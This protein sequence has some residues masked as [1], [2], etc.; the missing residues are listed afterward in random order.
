MK[1]ILEKLYAQA[2]LSNSEAKSLFLAILSPDTN[3][4]QIASVLTAFRMRQ[5][6]LDEIFGFRE[7]ALENCVKLEF[8]GIDVVDV[9]GT[10][11]D[12]KNTFNIS[13][14]SAIVVAACGLPV[15]KHGGGAVS[16][17]VGSSNLLEALGVKFT[18]DQSSLLKQLEACNLCF[19][20]A[21]IFHPSFKNVANIRKELG[22]K[23]I[24][25]LLGPI[26]NPAQPKYQTLGVYS[27]ELVKFYRF[28]GQKLEKNY[29]V[30]HTLDGCDEISLTSQAIV[31]DKQGEHLFAAGDFGMSNLSYDEIKEGENISSSV[32]IFN[33]VLNNNATEAQINVV[34][35]NSALTLFQVRKAKGEQSVLLDCVA[36]A[37]EA[38]VSGKA[39]RTFSKLLDL[40]K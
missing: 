1:E 20:H 25:N 13:T 39:R 29:S 5:V 19:L 2:P 33:N 4:F 36:E 12:N 23:T 37:K 18:N 24:F 7:A 3:Q 10:G 27:L 6:T 26:L 40:A 34:T 35:A 30:V 38:I 9:C 28:I 31:S 17:K 16:S 21:P 15:A 11:G 14:L 32:I 22:V 8:S